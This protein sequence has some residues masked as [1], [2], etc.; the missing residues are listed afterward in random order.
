MIHWVCPK[1]R[2]EY[3]GAAPNICICGYPRI[4][5]IRAKEGGKVNGRN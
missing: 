3:L 1:C 2:R 5:K 4:N